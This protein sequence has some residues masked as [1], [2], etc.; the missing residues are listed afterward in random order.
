MI[1]IKKLEKIMQ[2]LQFNLGAMPACAR[3]SKLMEAINEDR[4]LNYDQFECME[5]VVQRFEKV[6]DQMYAI[7]RETEWIKDGKF[8][9]PWNNI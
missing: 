7:E 9:K 8:H 4:H 3:L 1:Y 5:D 2:M 6:K